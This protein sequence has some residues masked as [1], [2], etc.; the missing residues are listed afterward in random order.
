MAGAACKVVINHGLAAATVA[1]ERILIDPNVH[2]GRVP[3]K[4]RG[5]LIQRLADC[6]LALYSGGKMPAGGVAGIMVELE[7]K[8]GVLSPEIWEVFKRPE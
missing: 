8:W 1:V 2:G 4:E 3:E 5:E 6:D 7:E